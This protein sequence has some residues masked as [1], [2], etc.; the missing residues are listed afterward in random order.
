MCLGTVLQEYYCVSAIL[1]LVRKRQLPD[2]A[3]NEEQVAADRVAKLI[4]RVLDSQDSYSVA[5][6]LASLPNM[7][8]PLQSVKIKYLTYKS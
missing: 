3:G 2:S 5:A 6:T 4:Q 7:V 8:C 1:G